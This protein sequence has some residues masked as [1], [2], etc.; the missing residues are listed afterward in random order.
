MYRCLS[1]FYHHTV[2]ISGWYWLTSWSDW[3]FASI[4]F[5]LAFLFPALGLIQKS[6]SRLWFC[7]EQTIYNSKMFLTISRA[8]DVFSNGKVMTFKIV[9]VHNFSYSY[10]LI[11][12]S[13]WTMQS[14]IQVN[15][16]TNCFIS[17]HQWNKI[18]YLR[19]KSNPGKFAADL[20][21]F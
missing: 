1:H 14:L 16:I 10:G 2:V 17:F 8:A 7:K 13:P 20:K 5:W 21:K 12:V 18:L 15:L 9:L 4:R 3:C 11:C 6:F 19:I